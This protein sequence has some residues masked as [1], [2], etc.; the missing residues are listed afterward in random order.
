LDVFVPTGTPMRP[1]TIAACLAVQASLIAAGCPADAKTRVSPLSAA[2]INAAKFAP[3]P[4]QPSNRLVPE[5]VKIEVLLDR[6]GFSPG[7]IDGIDGDNFRGALTAYQKQGGL[8]ATGVLDQA[9]WD[10]LLADAAPPLQNYTI[11][12]TDAKGPFTKEL[13]AKFEDEAKLK[14]LGYR[15]IREKLAEQF[16]MSVGLLQTLNRSSHFRPGQQIDVAA[17]KAPKPDGKVARIVV[18][19]PDH[20]VEAFAADGKLVAFYP[21]SIGSAEK[22]APTGEF[23]IRRIVHHP[24]YTYFPKFHFK[25]VS[26]TA[27]FTIAPGPR[28]PVGSVWIDLSYEGYGIHGTPNPEAIG[29]TESHGCIR[30]TNWD[31]ENLA[32][33]VDKGTPVFFQDNGTDPLAAKSAS[34]TPAA[35]TA[36]K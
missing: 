9:T 2:G 4:K 34:K 1:S 23:T 24:D 11:T 21:A 35:G 36:P 29:K 8:P 13:P 28:N 16:H 6:A 20:Q 17:V 7:A 5:V 22:P 14:Y 19:K 12:E 26:A 32:S 27:P 30:L 31:A 15:D 10:K 33:L 18:D 25:G 3:L